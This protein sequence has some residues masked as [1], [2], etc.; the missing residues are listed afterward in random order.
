MSRS[1][2]QRAQFVCLCQN[3]LQLFR[4]NNVAVRQHLKPEHRLVRFLYYNANLRDP[5]GL[6]TCPTGST[7]ICRHRCSTPQQLLP[8]NLSIRFIR[9]RPKN[10]H[11]P[12]RKIFSSISEVFLLR[13]HQVFKL[14]NYPITKL[15]N[16]HA[17]ATPKPAPPLPPSQT[18]TAVHPDALRT[19]SGIFSRTPSLASPPRLPT[20]KTSSP[21][22]FPTGNKCYR[23]L[24]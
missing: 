3:Q 13:L 17:G 24:S 15:Q 21:A 11:H 9:Q 8:P 14:Q 22:C 23:C 12:Y 1:G 7:I 19:L 4:R 6:R 16:F 10:A 20:D 18:G 5:L 2:E